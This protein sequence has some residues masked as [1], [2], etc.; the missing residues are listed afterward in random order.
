MKLISKSAADPI[1]NHANRAVVVV[2]SL[3]GVRRRCR[4]ALPPG[5]TNENSVGRVKIVAVAGI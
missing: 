1:G 5:V 2:V 3:E 4:E